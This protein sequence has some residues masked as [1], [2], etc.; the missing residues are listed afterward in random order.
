MGV[1]S[2]TS[3]NRNIPFN[4][5]RNIWLGYFGGKAD[6][7]HWNGIDKG[8]NQGSLEHGKKLCSSSSPTRCSRTKTATKTRKT[9]KKKKLRKPGCH[10]PTPLRINLVL[11]IWLLR[12][13]SQTY[14]PSETY[15]S[16][17]FFFLLHIVPA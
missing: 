6:V 10:K 9:E 5:K 1:A 3:N 11:E 8:W 12:E 13:P 16:S 2:Q 17:D 15:C 7:D 14:C 4:T